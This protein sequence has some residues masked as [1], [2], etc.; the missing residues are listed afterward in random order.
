LG[1]LRKALVLD[2]VVVEV[3]DWGD[4]LSRVLILVLLLYFLWLLDYIVFMANYLFFVI[5]VYF[6]ISPAPLNFDINLRIVQNLEQLPTSKAPK[7][8]HGHPILRLL[9][10][11]PRLNNGIIPD[12]PKPNRPRTILPAKMY[13]NRLVR[14]GGLVRIDLSAGSGSRGLELLLGGGGL[15]LGWG[16]VLFV[17]GAVRKGVGS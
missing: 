6:I 12:R 10:K 15:G 1:E 8:P 9:T 3:L 4:P 14:D 11:I 2:C 5:L 7:T 17:V 13:Q 16:C